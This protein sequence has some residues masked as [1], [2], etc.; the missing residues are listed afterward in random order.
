VPSSGFCVSGVNPSAAAAREIVHE[1]RDL[2]SPVLWV[3]RV[4]VAPA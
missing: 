1:V 3:P 4:K 2:S